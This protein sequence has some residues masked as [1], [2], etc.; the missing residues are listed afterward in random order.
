[1]K[2]DETT[3][4]DLFKTISLTGE[5][6][7][8]DKTDRETLEKASLKYRFSHSM[9]KQ[10]VDC[11]LDFASWKQKPLNELIDFTGTS[12]KEIFNYV[13]CQWND[14]KESVTDYDGFSGSPAPSPVKKNLV[15]RTA[16]NTGFGT[17]P[18][19]SSKTRCCN[20]LTLDAVEGCAFNCSYCAVKTFYKNGEVHL[21]DNLSQ[22]LKSIHI[23]RDKV[24]HIGTGQS[25]DSLL[26]GNIGGQLD[27]LIEFAVKY[28][29]VILEFKTKSSNI[30]YLLSRELPPNMIFTWSLNTDTIVNNEEHGTA[31]LDKRIESAKKMAKKGALVGFHF[32]PII[33]YKNSFAE[34]EKIF[35]R[36]VDEFDSGDVAMVSLG[37]LTFTKP[38][39]KQLRKSAMK[40]RVLEFAFNNIANKFSYST[41]IKEKMFSHAYEALEPWHDKVF[42][43]MCMED[44]VLW[45]KV[46]GYEY[47][48]NDLLED[49]MKKSYMN[50]VNI[51][52]NLKKKMNG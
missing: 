47:E 4:A 39:I 28:P 35:N 50:K 18:V 51:K 48:N 46:F 31:S 24:Y 41:D 2:K 20:L 1:M 49:A 7:A 6:A 42:F 34:Y 43:Y 29:N 12:G 17:C 13:V 14:L 10:M 22:T 23:D 21:I 40:S 30:E 25:S 11:G 16:D 26:Y 19:A 37:T 33:Y 36:L 8:L 32:H 27:A 3:K 5:F 9:L 45:K 44:I 52:I 15:L 38:V